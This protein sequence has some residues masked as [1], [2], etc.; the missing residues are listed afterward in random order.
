MAHRF[1]LL[2]E[3]LPFVNQKMEF[4]HKNVQLM[5]KKTARGIHRSLERSSYAPMPQSHVDG[6]SRNE[7]QAYKRLKSQVGALCLLRLYPATYLPLHLF[8]VVA[9]VD[10]RPP[11]LL[12]GGSSQITPS[13]SALELSSDELRAVAIAVAAASARIPSRGDAAQVYDAEHRPAP[14]DPRRT[15]R[16]H[17]GAGTVTATSNIVVNCKYVREARRLA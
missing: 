4:F 13:S 9:G 12:P 5:L 2:V 10:H 6:S 15:Q 1:A 14:A 16:L 8:F 17:S 7:E 3:M 11:L